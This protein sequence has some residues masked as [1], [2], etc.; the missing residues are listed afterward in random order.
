MIPFTEGAFK[1]EGK[2]RMAS[3]VMPYYTISLNQDTKNKENVGNSYNAYLIKDLLRGKY[4]YDGVVCTDWSVTGD[5]AAVDVFLTG[6]PW[7]VEKLSVAERHYKLLM[8][9]VD[10]FGGNNEAGP[11]IDA[12][13]MGVKEHRR[14]IDERTHGTISGAIAEEHFPDRTI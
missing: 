4:K 7:G 12:Y 5:E 10:Q 3:A 6:K 11:V 2:T 14:E 1:L 13:S 8:A 9:G